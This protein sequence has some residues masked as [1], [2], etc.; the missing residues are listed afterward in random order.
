MR[1]N[2]PIEIVPVI[3]G[4]VANRTISMIQSGRGA[5][6]GC[7]PHLRLPVYFVNRQLR[8]L[9]EGTKSDAET[10]TRRPAVC[11]D[12]EHRVGWAGGYVGN[13]V[14]AAHLAASTRA[15]GQRSEETSKSE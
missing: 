6:C 2:E 3:V 13:G 15:I 10:R 4:A 1:L 9:G 8:R 14:G 12:P 5:A 11:F 7:K